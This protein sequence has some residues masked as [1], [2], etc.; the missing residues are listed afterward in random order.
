M[1][2]AVTNNFLPTVDRLSATALRIEVFG[3]GES[4]LGSGTGFVVNSDTGPCLVTARHLLTGRHHYQGH[5]THSSG[6]DPKRIRIHHRMGE[7][8]TI[9]H[10]PIGRVEP[11]YNQSDDPLWYEDWE[12]GDRCDYALLPLTQFDNVNLVTVDPSFL[13]PEFTNA[14]VAAQMA[15]KDDMIV[16]TP[17][18][19]VSVVGY[20]FGRYVG[21]IFPIWT[22]G[23]LAVDL[24]FED[25]FGRLF[26]DSRTRSGQSGSPVYVKRRGD[27]VFSRS[28]ECI[29]EGVA[30]AFFGVYSGR[31]NEKSDIGV[32][33][34]GRRLAET[35]ARIPDLL[36][37]KNPTNRTIDD[38]W[39]GA[40]SMQ[41]GEMPVAG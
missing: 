18:D 25:P 19:P 29:I 15:G 27:V 31:V 36:T 3:G 2:N 32:V 5:L 39:L 1:S 23:S 33:Y 12:F 28:G 22:T 35:V 6:A 21:P 24:K 4:P 14:A 40:I 41:S 38:G 30:R 17:S 11:L 8:N 37:A 10:G 16:L 26:I 34:S 7:G 9:S 13:K 20:P